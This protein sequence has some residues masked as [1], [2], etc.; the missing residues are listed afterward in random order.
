MT[1]MNIEMDMAMKTKHN[2]MQHEE[3]EDNEYDA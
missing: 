2:T 1:T 3:K